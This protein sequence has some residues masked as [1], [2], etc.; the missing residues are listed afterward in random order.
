MAA[1]RYKHLG[2]VALDVTD[3]N[4]STAFH[5]ATIGLE[6]NP[7]VDP[8]RFGA[9]LLRGGPSACEI[10]L[11]EAPEPGLRRVAFEMENERYLELAHGHLAALGV[12]T[13]DVPAADRAAFA[14]RAAFRFAE[15]TTE[16]VV[17][18]YAG[19]G[20]P[21]APLSGEPRLTNISRLG[22]VVLCAVDAAALADFFVQQMNFR[23]S[24]YVGEFVFMRCFPNP[25]HHS[26][27]V[28]PA[29]SNRLNHVNFLVESLD[30]V[31]RAI[32]RT[33]EQQVEVV[34]GPGRHPPSGSVFLYFLDPDGMT[35][36][37]ST[38]MEEFPEAAS[39]EPRR[40]P[41]EPG[42]FDYWGGVPSNRF[43]AVGQFRSDTAASEK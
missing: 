37:L 27:A 21:P 3:R 15:P 39:R 2:Y 22:H 33:K 41:L 35:F 10:A 7:L 4:R 28:T 34:Y 9:T 13:W 40:L 24:D 17:E 5:Q 25:L 11:Y 29:T 1:L 32:N 20:S 8:A 43:S 19:D 38:G 36:E 16:L 6:P 18:L 30:D 12:R 23:V 14:Q 31:G 26:F 42:S